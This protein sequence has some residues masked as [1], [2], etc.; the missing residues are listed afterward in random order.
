AIGI[1]HRDD[2]TTNGITFDWFSPHA[3]IGEI[4]RSG[5]AIYSWSGYFDGANAMSA[6]KRYLNVRSPD[7]RLI[8]GPWDHGGMQVPGSSGR[9][10]HTRFDHAGEIVWFFDRH[11]KGIDDGHDEQPVHYFTTGEERWKAAGRWPPPGLTCSTL[12]LGENGTLSE[13]RP[14]D[15]EG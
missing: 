1:R 10:R 13:I 7:N 12:Y 14:A 4:E 6:V 11:L 5:A 15:I 3:F 9:V 8:L 2:A